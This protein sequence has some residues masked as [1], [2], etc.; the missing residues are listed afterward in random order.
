V[1][2]GNIDE[3]PAVLPDDNADRGHYVLNSIKEW[4]KK[5]VSFAKVNE[6]LKLI[7]PI[8]PNLPQSY[9]TLLQT[10]RD[11]E[12]EFRGDF[13]SW[14]EGIQVN[15]NQRLTDDFFDNHDTVEI[16]IFIDCFKPYTKR[17]AVS[18]EA[19]LGCLVG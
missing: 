2:P 10:P 5:G 18:F 13:E 4:A 11:I 12:L 8:Y 15:S 1:P 19:I 14:Y 7:R 9:Q 3:G 6:L 17:D 16:D